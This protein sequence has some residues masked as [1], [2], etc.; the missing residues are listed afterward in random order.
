MKHKPYWHTLVEC[1]STMEGLFSRDRGFESDS[2]HYFFYFE[3]C[4]YKKE[5]G[6]LIFLLAASN[7]N[8][9]IQRTNM[10]GIS[11]LEKTKIFKH[12]SKI[13]LISK[14]LMKFLGS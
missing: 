12:N 11:E 3:N 9:I 5:T 4:L 1:H 8:E 6:V 2:L 13:H 7:N 10:R 14:K